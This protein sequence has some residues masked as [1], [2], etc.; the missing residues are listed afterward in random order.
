MA[1]SPIA[2]LI[3]AGARARGLDPNA[4]L[5]VASQEGLSG[6]IGDG[7][8]AYGPFQLNNAGGVIT[9]QYGGHVNDPSVQQWATSPQGINFAL[10]RIA[11]VARGLHGA[12]AINAIVS[13]FERPANPGKEI[14]GATAAYGRFGGD[15]GGGPAVPPVQ[16]RRPLSA[17]MPDAQPARASGLGAALKMLGFSAPPSFGARVAA[18]FA[19]IAPIPEATGAA[20]TAPL[21]AGRGQIIG[22]TSGEQPGFVSRLAALAAFEHAPV[23]LS[24]GY[25]S[26]AKQSQL[27][28]DRASNPNP[29]AAPGHSLHEQG[30]AADGTIGGVPLGTLPDAVLARF[31]LRRVPGDPVHVEVAR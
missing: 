20:P 24:S 9:K 21:P 8:H 16:P 28:A 25:R 11:P 4:V 18:P 2:Q 15:A 3:A 22:D 7:G 12:Q 19:P 5:A 27:Y 14:A 17:L 6:G 30:L 13:Q 23:K 10:D 26:F 29:V 31:G 1:T